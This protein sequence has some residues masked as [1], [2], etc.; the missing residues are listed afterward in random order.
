[1]TA[2]IQR[3]VELGDT[4]GNCA[5]LFVVARVCMNWQSGKGCLAGL[6]GQSRRWTRDFTLDY[7]RDNDWNASDSITRARGEAD[8]TTGSRYPFPV[9]AIQ[10]S[11]FWRL[12]WWIFR[13]RSMQSNESSGV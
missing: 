10:K 4:H 6:D 8:C 13:A 12:S 3:N 5:C 1:V 7:V 11:L 2:V 9:R